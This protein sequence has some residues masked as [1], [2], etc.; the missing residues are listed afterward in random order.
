MNNDNKKDKENIEQE[1]KNKRS[2]WKKQ[3]GWVCLLLPKFYNFV[4][5]VRFPITQQS[6]YKVNYSKYF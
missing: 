1:K 6:S 2:L 5:N 3:V 4:Q